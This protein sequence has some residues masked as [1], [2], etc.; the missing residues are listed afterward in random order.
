MIVYFGADHGG[1]EL[2]E[3]LK[4]FVKDLG[5]ELVDMG[6]AVLDQS[7]DYPDFAAA[8]AA[9]VAAEGDM[10]KG[11]LVCRSGAG[12]DITANKFDGV[13]SVL[14]VN[15]DQVYDARHDDDVNVLSLEAGFVTEA[16]AEKMVRIFMQTPFGGEER[17]KRRLDKIRDI[18]KTN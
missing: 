5:Y 17:Y 15:P 16:D 12:V 3:R 14:G 7:D 9:K 8:V 11:I 4:T 2:K 18:E 13:R 1:F 10:A 6:N